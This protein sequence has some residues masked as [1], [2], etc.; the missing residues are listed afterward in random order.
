[1]KPRVEVSTN[2][3]SFILELDKGRAPLTV[4]NF[5]K[6]VNEDFYSGTIFHRVVQG[7]IA[8]AGGYDENLDAKEV[9]VNIINESGNGLSN[10]RGTVGLARLNS[11]HSGNTQFYI[12]LSDN[13]DLNPRPTRWGYTVFGNVVNGMEIIDEIGHV[14]TSAKGSFERNVPVDSIIIE[15]IELLSN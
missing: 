11:P 4:E 12:N 3:G 5:L 9:E 6:Y 2:V 14:S 7:F 13:L 8:Q 10:L 1:M 15:S